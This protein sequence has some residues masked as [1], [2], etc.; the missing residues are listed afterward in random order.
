MNLQLRLNTNPIADMKLML[1][2]ASTRCFAD[3]YLG[4]YLII[5][6]RVIGSP[7]LLFFRGLAAGSLR[8]FVP[9]DEEMQHFGFL[10]SLSNENKDEP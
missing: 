3:G 9:V 10:E 1:L 4:L 8:G 6:D 2:E 5:I 7:E